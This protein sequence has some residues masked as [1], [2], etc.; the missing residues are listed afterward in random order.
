[1]EKAF[2]A[3]G[4]ENLKPRSKPYE[5]PDP[6]ARGLRVTVYPSG[7]KSYI[8]RYRNAA[9]RTRKLT[10]APGITLAAARKLAA[11]AMFEV[12]QDR[13]PSAAKQ[14]AKKSAIA[15]AKKSNAAPVDDSVEHWADTFIARHAS[16]KS[17]STLRQVKHVFDDIALPAWKGRS[18]HDIK[19]RDIID[20]LDGVAKDKPIMANRVQAVLSKFFKWLK[21][22]VVIEA[23]PCIGVERPSEENERDRVL[24]V[25]E[26]KTLWKACDEIGGSAGACVQM[27]LL[28]GQRRNEI[29][30]MR[31]SE[32]DGDQWTIPAGR[33]KGRKA[34]TIP[35]PAQALA[36]IKRMP[37]IGD[38]D[39]VFTI[40]G[41]ARLGHFDRIKREIDAK[42]GTVPHWVLHDIRRTT[43]SSMAA[44]GIPVS[45]IEKILAHVS[46]TF[47]GIVGV[48]QRHSFGPEMKSALQKWA[49]HAEQIVTGKSGAKVVPFRGARA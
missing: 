40:T 45:T 11:D 38:G 21:S 47:K 8:V 42:M 33:M 15:T 23:S 37:R 5:M 41:K 46:G 12:A 14:T 16:K 27:M 36:I 3:I 32:I 13:D 20:L 30:G 18:V 17:E 9:G 10:L 19:P 44:I 6:G 22:R 48:Y 39:L 43:A 7:R 31:R 24:S 26:I 29:T 28:L 4:I 2:T 1:V 25:A 34:H 35:L 49:D